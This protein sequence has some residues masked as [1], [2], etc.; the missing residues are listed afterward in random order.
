MKSVIY[1]IDFF[2][3]IVIKKTEKEK[4]INGEYPNS[5]KTLPYL[6]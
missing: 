5:D 2:R 3:S 4:K 6:Y 1:S